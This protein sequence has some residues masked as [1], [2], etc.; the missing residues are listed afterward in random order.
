MGVTINQWLE[1]L[2]DDFRFAPLDATT[3]L[4]LS[5][6]VEERFPLQFPGLYI[7]K[8]IWDACDQPTV[9]IQ[10]TDPHEQLVFML[11]YS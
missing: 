6:K 5:Q 2:I 9:D 1:E 10:F 11:K 8:C 7:V 4:R 3:K